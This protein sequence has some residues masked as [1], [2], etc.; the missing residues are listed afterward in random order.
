M[1]NNI[2]DINIV[3]LAAGYLL[4]IIPMA[5]I[6]LKR[7]PMFRDAVMAVIRMTVQLV[8]VGFYLQVVF[9]LNKPWLNLTWVILMVLVADIS[10]IRG[11][12]LT[13]RRFALP[14]FCALTVGTIVPVLVFTIPILR[15]QNWMDAQY[16]I[17]LAGMVLGNCLR[18]DI[19][20]LKDF[21]E[22]IVKN[23]KAYFQSLAQGADH[24]EALAP[25]FRDAVQAALL[26][27]TASMA[28]IGLVALPGM[29]TGVILAGASPATAIKYQIAIMIAIFSGT[30]ITVFL[31]VRLSIYHS[32]N[33]YGIL[34]R[35][36]FARPPGA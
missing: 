12:R 31:A 10:I 19:V 28:T 18:A 26:P 13:I 29:M 36:V 6:L 17:P 30:A 1:M 8:F 3:S 22:S 2:I 9:D 5:V 4:L 25:Y 34:D 21:Y 14:L 32:F 7:V 16:V 33:K 20:G 11:C 27:T 24:Q 35:K 23:E 15:L